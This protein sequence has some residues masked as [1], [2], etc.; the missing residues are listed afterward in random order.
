V[1]VNPKARGEG[2]GSAGSPYSTLGRAL[3]DIPAST[4]LTQGV[5]IIVSK[6]RPPAGALPICR[7]ISSGRAAAPPSRLPAPRRPAAPLTLLS[8][9]PSL[10]PPPRLIS[11]R[12]RRRR[13]HALH[14]RQM[15]HARRA[16]RDRGRCAGRRP[17]VHRHGALLLLLFQGSVLHPGGRGGAGLGAQV[18]CGIRGAAGGSGGGRAQAP[19]CG[20]S[21]PPTRPHPVRACP[22]SLHLPACSPPSRA[23]AGTSSTCRPAVAHASCPSAPLPPPQSPKQGSGGDVVHVQACD[24]VWFLGVTMTGLKRKKP[25]ETMKVGLWEGRG[26]EEGAGGGGERASAHAPTRPSPRPSTHPPTISFLRP[27]RSRA[28]GWR[29]AKSPW[30]AGTPWTGWQSSTATSAARRL[31]S[32][33]G[34]SMSKVRALGVAAGGDGPLCGPA[35]RRRPLPRRAAPRR[36]RPRHPAA[37]AVPRVTVPSPFSPNSPPDAAPPPPPPHS[38]DASPAPPR[39]ARSPLPPPTP[40]RLLL[41]SHR[42]K[43]RLKLRRGGPADRPGH[44][45]APA[46]P[47]RRGPGAHRGF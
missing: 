27:T 39:P 29:T 8:T 22:P 9:R 5:H 12:C 45:C 15:G 19:D 37:R 2:D 21:P 38:P 25:Q 28:C 24:Y 43:R 18:G 31:P 1:Y 33:R 13:Q 32:R 4:K 47:A 23:A 44:G 35:A 20:G 16:R 14:R 11:G 10:I 7:N 41:H 6:A 36:A 26:R 34:A 46:A 3:Q 42:F 40:R 30:V 17:T